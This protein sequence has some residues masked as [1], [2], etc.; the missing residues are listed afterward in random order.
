MKE[1]ALKHWL[2]AA[3]VILLAAVPP[4]ADQ[5]PNLVPSLLSLFPKHGQQWVPIVGVALT[6]AAHVIRDAGMLDRVR[7]LLSG[8]GDGNAAQ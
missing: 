1:L 4:L 7:A 8:R 5:Y 6:V 3:L 2:S